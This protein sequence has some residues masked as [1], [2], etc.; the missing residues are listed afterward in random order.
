MSGVIHIGAK[1]TGGYRSNRLGLSSVSTI[2][3][4]ANNIEYIFSR[5]LEANPRYR[6]CLLDGSTGIASQYAINAVAVHQQH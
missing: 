5:Y 6:N 3:C 2:T 4:L 1:L